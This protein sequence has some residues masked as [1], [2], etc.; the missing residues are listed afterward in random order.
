MT[1][2]GP[3]PVLLRAAGTAVLLDVEGPELP[4]VL[5]WGADPGDLGE[6]D[7]RRLAEDLVPAVPNSALDAVWPLTLVPGEVDGWS[8]RPGLAGHRNGES[9][10]P[11]LVLDGPASVEPGP[12]GGGSLHAAARDEE[13]GLGVDVE[14]RLAS[15]GVL[16]VIVSVTNTGP[17]IYD[18]A[19]LSALLPVPGRAG[20]LLDLTGRWCRERS[21][22]RQPFHQGSRV[23]EC[24]RGRTGHDATLL[25]VAGTPGF[26]FRSGE[27]WATHVAWSGNHVH[28]ADRLPEGAGGLPD[29][30]VLGGGELLHPGEVRLRTGE[31]YRAPAVYFAWSHEGLD[32]LSS[33]LYRDLRARSSHPHRARPLVLNTW[34]AVYFDHDR[35]RLTQLAR[36]AADIGVERFVLDD[37]WFRGRRDERAGLGD[38][39]EDPEHWPD[40]LRPLAEFVRGLGMEFGLWVEPEMV[41]PHSD[42]AREHPD[43]LLAP[44]G[45]LG[46]LPRMWRHQAVLD[47]AHPAAFAHILQRLDTLVQEVGVSFLKWDHN[48]DLHESWHTDAGGRRAGVHTQTE[49]V[50]ALLDTLRRRHPDLEIESCASGGARVD[51]GILA[52]TDRIWASDTNDA[53]ERQAIQRW[54]GLLVPPELVG[55]HVGPPIAHTTGRTG[56]LS[57]RALTSLFG[58]AGIE[59]DITSC[60]P[61]ELDQLRS[62]TALYRELRGLLHTGDVVRTDGTDEAWLHGVVATDR[63]EAVFC[64]ARLATGATAGGPRVRLPGLDPTTRYRV[65]RRNDAGPARPAGIA[66]PPWWTRG[67]TEGLGASLEHVGLPLPVLG[68]GQAV[69]MHVV[70]G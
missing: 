50:Y 59:W 19:S 45:G 56:D 12:E 68:P 64:Y 63:S 29:G 42:L 48:R 43:W 39:Y 16:R 26:G 4:R 61:A 54:T 25:L 62:W 27:V 36:A 47:I 1:D 6:E 24:R 20:E 55:T 46:R 37:G 40:G 14:L 33:R 3:A 67:S 11:R 30:A 69:L 7:L 57:F 18:V 65:T 23:R 5:H 13:N 17:G 32:G 51:L 9:V 15:T 21:P 10:F 31:T 52:R 34:E 8:G 58:H 22:Q 2:T 35:D 38:W 70:A 60:T 66:S 28:V 41:N 53:L 44:A 49:A